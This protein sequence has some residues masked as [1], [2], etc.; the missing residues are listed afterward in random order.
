V[1]VDRYK[2]LTIVNR[3]ALSTGEAV[4][5]IGIPLTS[6]RYPVSELYRAAVKVSGTDSSGS[7]I[8]EIQGDQ[9]D[10]ARRLDVDSDLVTTP[11]MALA[12]ALVTL[13][14]VSEIR[15]QRNVTVEDDGTLLSVF[16]RVTLEGVSYVIYKIS[17][18]LEQGTHDLTLLEIVS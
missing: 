11:G 3:N 7:P 15:R 14:F 6:T 12:C 18:D 8:N 17:T 4:T 2:V 1:D 16:D 5:D 9:G 13:A 10:S